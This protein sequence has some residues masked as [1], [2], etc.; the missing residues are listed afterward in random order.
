MNAKLAA[1]ALLDSNPNITLQE[2][3][4][5][6][7]KLGPKDEDLFWI[8]VREIRPNLCPDW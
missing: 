4:A 2:L 3:S 1:K 5:Y 6:A 7:A 8:G